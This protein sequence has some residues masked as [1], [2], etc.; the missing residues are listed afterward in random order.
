M[1]KNILRNITSKVAALY[2]GEDYQ[3]D[4]ELPFTALFGFTFDKIFSLGRCLCRCVVISLDPR[5]LIFLGANVELKNRKMI[6]F[7]RGVTLGKYVMIDGLSKEGIIIGNGSSIGPY[8]IIRA[9]GVLSNLGKGFRMGNH[10]SLDA[11]AFVGCSG[12][13]VIG[14][15]VIL[16]QKVSFHSENHLFTRS[17]LLIRHQGITRQGI[18][19]EDD[20]W[21]GSNV[22]FLDGAHVSSGCVIGAGSI[23]RGHIPPNSIAV[24]VP[25]R[26]INSRLRLNDE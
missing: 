7:G 12:G 22:T 13:V 15:N 24:G 16:G 17:D 2:K 26:V 20:C 10:S 19:I 1:V 5:D 23:V 25:A 4:P 11:F 9:T 14:N 8:G 21:V 6:Q 3:I 18:V